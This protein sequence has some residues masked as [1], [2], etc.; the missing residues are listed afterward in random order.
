MGRAKVL[1]AKTKSGKRN[2]INVGNYQKEAKRAREAAVGQFIDMRHE[3]IE[4]EDE[5][6]ALQDEFGEKKAQLN[7]INA[8]ISDINMMLERQ[9][10]RLAFKTK[11]IKD[12]E[13]MLKCAKSKFGVVSGKKN[14]KFPIILSSRLRTIRQKDPTSKETKD[15]KNEK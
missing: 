11:K 10:K 2:G 1:G 6:S 15:L 9:R 12:V 3:V 5:L 14:E 8:E 13:E 7:K 4:T